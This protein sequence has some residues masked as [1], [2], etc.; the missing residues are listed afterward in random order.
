MAKIIKILSD[1]TSVEEPNSLK[2]IADD[3]GDFHV[4]LVECNDDERGIR[5][6]QSGSRHS[7]RVREALRNLV[8]VY[9][10]ELADPKCNP[11]LKEHN[12][13]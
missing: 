12:K 10:E 3:Q 8:N 4:S 11:Q 13:I 7:P 2:I 9:Q 1:Y 5:I 6:A